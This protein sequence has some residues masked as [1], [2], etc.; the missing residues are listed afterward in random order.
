MTN[1]NNMVAAALSYIRRGWEVFPV[2]RGT[3]MGYSVKQRS[4]D[5]GKPWGKTRDEAEVR[6]YWSRLSRANI[7]VAMGVASGIFDIECDTK[8]GHSK[9][10]QDG[11][12]SLAALEAQHGKLPDTLMFISPSGSLHRL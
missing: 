4:F 5:N 6:A 7:G 9:L 8:A 10:K 2:P 11:A 12:A 1:K 3:K